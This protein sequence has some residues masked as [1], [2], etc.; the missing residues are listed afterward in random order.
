MLA[1]RLGGVEVRLNRH[2]DSAPDDAIPVA[3]AQAGLHARNALVLRVGTGTE[4][5]CVSAQNQQQDWW[6]HVGGLGA[7]TYR[8]TLQKADVEAEL[9]PLDG[10]AN[11]ADKGEGDAGLPVLGRLEDEVVQR[12]A[13]F[14]V[15]SV[16]RCEAKEQKKIVCKFLNIRLSW[17][18]C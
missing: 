8:H 2:A 1:A 16:E 7:N 14:C 17:T 5:V 15:L 11:D 9:I 18:L 6:R 12:F 10:G 3:P 13:N 4:R